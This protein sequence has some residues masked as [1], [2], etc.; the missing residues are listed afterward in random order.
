MIDEELYQFA[1]DELNSDRRDSELWNRACALARDD[2]DEARFLYTNLRV[3]ELLEQK[4]N[5]EPMPEMP[6]SVKG[7]ASVAFDLD[8][9]PNAVENA[10]L[11]LGSVVAS[12][13]LNGDAEPEAV[14]SS[15]NR[16]F[17]AST[18]SDLSEDL[19]KELESSNQANASD[20]DALVPDFEQ[21]AKNELDEANAAQDTLE[22]PDSVSDTNESS[23]IAGTETTLDMGDNAVNFDLDAAAALNGNESVHDNNPAL[24]EDAL[25]DEALP[26]V[27]RDIASLAA[28][29]S[30]QLKGSATAGNEALEDALDDTVSLDNT[31]FNTDKL[32]SIAAE[33]GAFESLDDTSI[34]SI[35]TPL[36]ENAVPESTSLNESELAFCRQRSGID[37]G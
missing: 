1:T 18:S 24:P 30:Q 32:D 15:S 28:Q 17:S 36:P 3:E 9:A 37:S 4:A 27:D 2:H 35:A 11:G 13:A 8:A 33:T 22:F 16:A 20:D 19:I 14:V 29:A 26:D 34:N 23:S 21:R 5:G 10:P 12:E 31:P 7:A 6:E 25:S